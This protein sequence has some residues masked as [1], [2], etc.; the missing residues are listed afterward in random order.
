M[1]KSFYLL[2]LVMVFAVFAWQDDS[3]TWYSYEVKTKQM[4]VQGRNTS[5]KT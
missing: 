5:F 2:L 4:K 3:L 1:N